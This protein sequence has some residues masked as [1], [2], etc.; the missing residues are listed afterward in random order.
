MKWLLLFLVGVGLI[1]YS[2]V[3]F[4]IGGKHYS[5]RGTTTI[6]TSTPEDTSDV[7]SEAGVSIFQQAKDFFTVGDKASTT[8]ETSSTPENTITPQEAVPNPAPSSPTPPPAQTTTTPPPVTTTQTP[9]PATPTIPSNLQDNKSALLGSI[10]TVEMKLDEDKS[11]AI[12]DSSDTIT[13]TGIDDSSKGVEGRFEIRNGSAHRYELPI[14][15]TQEIPVTGSARVYILE[16]RSISE[17]DDTASINIKHYPRVRRFNSLYSSVFALPYQSLEFNAW[18]NHS[19]ILTAE[20]I[21]RTHVSVEAVTYEN[22]VLERSQTGRNSKGQEIE[23]SIADITVLS[24]DREGNYFYQTDDAQWG[25]HV[26][27]FQVVAK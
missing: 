21:G 16:V 15:A 25:P 8:N 5:E 18:P 11:V 27:E 1:Y 9:S 2:L 7:P 17:S 22:G 20:D 4:N 24:I 6:A 12:P 10:A 19:L 13:L 23:T 14:G 26:V 3:G